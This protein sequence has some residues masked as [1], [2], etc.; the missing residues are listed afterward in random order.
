VQDVLVVSI[1]SENRL[2][3]WRKISASKEIDVFQDEAMKQSDESLERFWCD[4]AGP[5]SGKIDD[6]PSQLCCSRSIEEP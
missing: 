1:I 6:V 3:F 4:C 2:V 5:G